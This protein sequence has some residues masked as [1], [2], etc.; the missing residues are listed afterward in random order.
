VTDSREGLNAIQYLAHS[1]GGWRT[2]SQDFL[3]WQAIYWWF[4]CII[5]RFMFQTIRD[6]ALM[7]DGVTTRKW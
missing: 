2:L 1:D 7:L 5:W 3:P 6:V 4:R